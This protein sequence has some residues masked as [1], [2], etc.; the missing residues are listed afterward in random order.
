[1]SDVTHSEPGA[2]PA[3]GIGS[4]LSRAFSILSKRFW[5]LFG[6]TF[7]VQLVFAIINVAVPSLAAPQVLDP[8]TGAFD[9]TALVPI[10]ASVLLAMLAYAV[11]QGIVTVAAYDTATGRPSRVG[12]YFGAVFRNIVPLLVVSILS[13]IAIYVGILLLVVPGLWLAAVLSV[14]VPAI[15][16]DQ[17]GFGAFGRSARL[18]KEYRWP[19]VGFLIV[20]FLIFFGVTLLL[21]AI[22]FAVLGVD[23][24]AAAALAAQTGDY[25]AAA[26]VYTLVNAVVGAITYSFLAVA[27]AV[28]FARLKEIKE[29]LGLEDLSQVFD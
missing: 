19:I 6:L 1:M 5:L 14:V 29:G 26:L 20:V 27:V 23:G 2:R 12:D 21:G 11:V 15:V 22:S 3:L 9:A 16:V 17:A 4:I 25:S 10:L 24:T 7:A 28:L 18:T 13:A 8:A